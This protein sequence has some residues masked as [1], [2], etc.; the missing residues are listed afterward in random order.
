[1]LN[2]SHLQGR[3]Y[4]ALFTPLTLWGCIQQG[5]RGTWP[6]P[7]GGG[8]KEKHVWLDCDGV[9]K[10]E[11]KNRERKSERQKTENIIAE[12][13]LSSKQSKIIQTFPK[14]YTYN[15]C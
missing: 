6:T 2:T 3:V 8:R 15:E 4:S 14:I 7:K 12:I 1:M 5:M 13:L 10:V 11:E 9:D